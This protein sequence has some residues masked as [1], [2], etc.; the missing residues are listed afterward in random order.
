MSGNPNNADLKAVPQFG[1]SGSVP[2]RGSS[3]AEAV[4]SHGRI[5]EGGERLSKAVDASLDHAF[6]QL[7]AQDMKGKMIGRW[8]IEK[9]I[10]S[11]GFGRVYQCHYENDPQRLGAVKVLRSN[12]SQNTED[13]FI[14]EIK[15]LM[16][17]RH[18]NIVRVLEHAWDHGFKSRFF[19]MPL[20]EGQTLRQ[21][22]DSKLLS[23]SETIHVMEQVLS[24]I[25]YAHENNLVHQDIK[26]QNLFIDQAGKITVLDFGIARP[27]D[28]TARG[29]WR[30]QGYCPPESDDRKPDGKLWDIYSCGIVLY[31]LLT[32]Q[33][34]DAFSPGGGFDPGP[35]ASEAMRALVQ[36]ATQKDPSK[37]LQS[38]ELFLE[39]IRGLSAP[40]SPAPAHPASAQRP[41]VFPGRIYP[42]PP[43]L[44]PQPDGEETVIPNH[45]SLVWLRPLA[46]GGGM[47]VG[48]LALTLF[49][50][51][52]FAPILPAG[53][54]WY[55][56]MGSGRTMLLVLGF[57]LLVVF[58][59]LGLTVSVLRYKA[60]RDAG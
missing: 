13:Q 47:G 49:L 41:K 43:P 54:T 3:P 26:P 28:Q 19:V 11:G 9:S 5:L 30:T 2:E 37:R 12:A 45:G 46:L 4:D 56:I 10:G 40:V 36:D 60:L 51:V 44:Q 42:I 1:G 31:E 58:L 52:F 16:E 15:A 59:S 55:L 35:P 34:P 24:A 18:P 33:Q 32:G 20:L 17:L 27:W 6:K 48:L 22:M 29:S 25:G 21:W 38:V 14:T 39:R 50:P 7:Q 23:T 8:V 53:T 57:V